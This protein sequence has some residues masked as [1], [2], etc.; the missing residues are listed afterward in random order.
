MP[1]IGIYQ[2]KYFIVNRMKVLLINPMDKHHWTGI[3]Y[4]VN[5]GA[6]EDPSEYNQFAHLMEHIIANSSKNFE[7][8]FIKQQ[9]KNF[10]AETNA[11]TS[12]MWTH[13]YYIFE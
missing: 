10:N 8:K 13:Y 6:L 7:K 5:F 1:I 9:V 4:T 2:F 12:P 11:F 3:F